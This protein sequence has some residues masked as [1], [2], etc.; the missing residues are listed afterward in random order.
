M[1]SKIGGRNAVPSSQEKAHPKYSQ[2]SSMHEAN[3]DVKRKATEFLTGLKTHLDNKLPLQTVKDWIDKG[4]K[5][6]NEFFFLEKFV[7]PEIPEYLRQCLVPPVTHNDDAHI[8]DAF[9]A[10][11]KKLRKDCSASASPASAK[12]YLFTKV[13]FDQKEIVNLWWD[14]GHK[15]RQTTQSCPDWAFRTP[16]LYKVVFEGKLFRKGDKQRARAELVNGIYQCFYYLAHPHTAE[17]RV[18]P[19]WDYD[20]ACLFVYDAS[21]NKSLVK[22]WIELNKDVKKACWDSS[23][24]FVM[25]LPAGKDAA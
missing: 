3:S 8:R 9:L 20:Y 21:E 18:H 25:V 5:S 16:C 12:K 13:G 17:D 7:L 11:S 22:A 6:A 23:N 19:P 1:K 10:E 2:R 24:I 15:K 4:G 14:K